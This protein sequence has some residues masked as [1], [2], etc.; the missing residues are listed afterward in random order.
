MTQEVL[1]YF[2]II[3]GYTFFFFNLLKEGRFSAFL[4]VMNG[5]KFA[6]YPVWNAGKKLLNGTCNGCSRV[7]SEI[8]CSDSNTF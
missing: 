7:Q 3:Q 5:T 1:I 4:K 8:Q 6:G 2:H